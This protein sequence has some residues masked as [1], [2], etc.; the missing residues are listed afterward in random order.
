MASPSSTMSTSQWFEHN[1]KSISNL[2]LAMQPDGGKM[3][4]TKTREK[5]PGFESTSHGTITVSYNFENGNQ[6][7]EHLNPGQPYYAKYFPRH[8]YFPDNSHGNK[9]LRMLKMA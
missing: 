5:L 7:P 6:S 2:R 9:V 3:K 8:T 4:I 1:N